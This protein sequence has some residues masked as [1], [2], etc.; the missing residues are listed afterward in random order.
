VGGAVDVGFLGGGLRRA[1]G[2]DCEEG[3][4]ERERVC[5]W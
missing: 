2:L 1:H 4:V 3:G 5:V